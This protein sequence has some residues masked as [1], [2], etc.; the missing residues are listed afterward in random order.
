[1]ILSSN[2]P[3]CIH[4]IVSTT[5]DYLHCI[6]CSIHYIGLSTLDISCC[7]T[8]I[9]LHLVPYIWFLTLDIHYIVSHNWIIYIVSPTF[10]YLHLITYIALYYLYWISLA[11]SSTLYPYIVSL[12]CIPYIV[13][14]TLDYLH[15][16]IYIGYPLLYPLHLITLHCILYIGYPL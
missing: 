7:I 1:M 9:S 14:L 5:F 15:C 13:F 11:V 2:S 8:I 4:Y 12:H 6:H 16:I 3:C 10:D